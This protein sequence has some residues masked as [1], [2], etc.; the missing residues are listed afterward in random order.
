MNIFKKMYT[1][2]M[3]TKQIIIDAAFSIFENKNFKRITV[4][5][6][7]NKADVSRATFYK[8]FSGKHELMHL[9]Y[10]TYMDRNIEENYN[11]NNWREIAENLLAYIQNNQ[12]YFTNVKDTLGQDSFWDFIW[13][14]SYDFY[15][16]VKQHNEKRDHLT[17]NERLTIISHLHG[18]LALLKMFIEGKVNMSSGEFAELICSTIPDS[19]QEYK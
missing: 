14:Y 3:N 8:Y 5:D 2:A 7:L 13:N 18:G 1:G 15:S 16:S 10:R 11:G 19:Y 9:Y 12:P 6:I 17:E 4:Q